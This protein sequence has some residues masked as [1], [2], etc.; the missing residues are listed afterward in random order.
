MVKYSHHHEKFALVS[1]H[2]SQPAVLVDGIPSSIS[3]SGC[4]GSSPH[5]VGADG[6][7]CLCVLHAGFTKERF[8]IYH[9][10]VMIDHGPAPDRGQ[11][12]V[13]NEQEGSY[14]KMRGHSRRLLSVLLALVMLLS[15][16]PTA[17]FAAT[18]KAKLIGYS[19]KEIEFSNG[20]KALISS[21]KFKDFKSKYLNYLKRKSIGE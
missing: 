15:L 20:Q 19:K 14:L 2:P 11:T 6:F 12:T 4:A 18:P 16:L 3:C 10:G 21:S 9:I 5:A 17:V 8:R 1:R 7:F 13:Q